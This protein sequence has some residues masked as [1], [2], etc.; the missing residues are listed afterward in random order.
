MA[1]QSVLTRAKIVLVGGD[2]EGRSMWLVNVWGRALLQAGVMRPFDSAGSITQTGII[3][4]WFRNLPE[5]HLE[6]E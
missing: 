6:L 4:P 1:T 2:I 5:L 3:W